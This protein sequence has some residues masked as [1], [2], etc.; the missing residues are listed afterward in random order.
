MRVIHIVGLAC[1]VGLVLFLGTGQFLQREFA[2]PAEEVGVPAPVV[3]LMI[4]DGMG[5][6]LIEAASY[7]RAGAPDRLALQAL[8]H[9]GRLTT[10]NAGGVTDSAAAA[11]AMATGHFTTNQRVGLGAA[12]QTLENL[13]EFSRAAGMV[14]GIVTTATLPHATPAA[15]TAHCNSRTS[16]V[17][18]A[19]QQVL[20]QLHVMLGGGLAYFLP[21]GKLSRRD[22]AGLLEPMLAAGYRV[23]TSKHGL[24]RAVDNRA[25][26]LLGLFA[27]E[28]IPYVLSNAATPSLAGMSMAAIRTL[29]RHPGGFFLMIEGARID[30]AAHSNHLERAIGEVLA[31]DDAVAAV[32]RWIGIR[33]DVLLLVTADHDTGG[34]RLLSTPEAGGYPE[35]EWRSI[36]HTDERVAITGLGPGSQWFD[37]E[38]R[39]HRWVH[40]VSR[41]RIEDAPLVPPRALRPDGALV[42][43]TR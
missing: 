18:I 17:A 21:R 24:S 29:E 8:P 16:G 20:A 33:E 12:G 31:F 36:H 43:G 2:A 40:A 3:I 27:L 23:V 6:G 38:L 28:H 41:A 11:T 30:M 22:D 4:G 5:D 26:R 42:A 14:T 10:V 7:Y 15:F 19:D 9:R 1:L 37:G 25:E 35:V 13:V 32:V 39:D 34:L